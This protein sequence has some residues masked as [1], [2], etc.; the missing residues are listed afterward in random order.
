[1]ESRLNYSGF[2][3]AGLAFF[4]TRFTVTLAL[5]DTV[6]F[7]LAGVVPLAV[8]LG[9]A[10][11]GV[12]LTVADV[13]P[14]MVR[15]TA[16]W[17]VIGFGTMLALVVLTILGSSSG[18]VV[19]LSTVRSQTYL[20][21]FLIGGSVGGTLTGLYAS[22]NRRQR[23]ELRQQ[24]NRLVTLNRLL[25]HEILNAVTAIRG[26]ASVGS[27]ETED[28]MTVIDERAAHIQQT[29]ED[30]KYLTER[31]GAGGSSG[32]PRDLG[33][34]LSESVEAVT[35]RHPSA[36]VSV[37]SPS[38]PLHVHANDRLPVVFTQLLENAIVHGTDDTPTVAVDA[39]PTTVSVSIEDDGP[40]LPESQQSLLESGDIA[41]FDDPSVGFGLNIVRLLVESYGGTLETD[42]SDRG[43]TVTVWLPRATN[44]RA[45]E[46]N[47]ADLTGVR[48][49]APHLAVTCLAAIAAGVPYALVSEFLGGSIAGIGVFY[50]TA[51]PVVGWLTHEFHS[52]VF[53]FMY[54]GL[55]S[56][57]LDRY[58]NT[59]GVY[60]V[61]G[62]AWSLSVWVVAAGFVAP[63]WLQLVGTPAPVPNLSLRL[64]ASHLAWGVSLA[65]LTFLGYR[66]VTPRLA[67]VG[68]RL[69]AL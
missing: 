62:L 63:V 21:N 27:S 19:D 7:Y 23:S 69:R 14:G 59:A 17:C 13:D 54:V 8:G 51:D 12:A 64:L 52:V 50:G 20:S 41:E 25:R 57:A 45:R 15:T 22:R 49:A 5:E 40:G 11:F 9:L 10:A 28:G 38:A 48:P 35:D 34:A 55:L 58:R 42:V 67:G 44:E 56:L 39:S 4:L 68:Q 66:Y 24:A 33:A 29:I 6:Q 36:R 32:A 30:V 1:M 3:V 46:P 47:R 61:T 60:A 37:D 65:A 18:G 43:T 2:V 26:Y 16:V 53:G 31:T